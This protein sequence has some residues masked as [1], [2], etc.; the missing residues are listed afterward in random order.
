MEKKNVNKDVVI[1]KATENDL[2]PLKEISIKTFCETFAKYNTPEETQ[3]YID[4][5]FTDE[6][7]LKEINTK[8]SSFYLAYL[9]DK[10]IAYLKLNTGE[11]Q[12]EEQ[13]NES[14]EIQ[15]IYVLAE[16]KGKGI[17]SLL[18]QIAE[19]EASKANCK[20]IWLGVWE[21]NDDAIAFYTKKGYKRFSEHIFMYGSEK[22]T[23][24]LM[25]KIIK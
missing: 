2:V 9:K 1:K 4:T 11:A 17:G 15:R 5:N 25:E 16:C 23:D 21:H 20:R 24:Y 12:T 7:I 19:E 18:M 6:Q 3:K 8:G 22:Q 14:I 10:V 13:G